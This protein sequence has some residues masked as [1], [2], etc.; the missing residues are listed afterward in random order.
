MTATSPTSARP[1]ASSPASWRSRPAP[2]SWPAW[3]RSASALIAGVVCCYAVKLKT[4]AGY[5]DALDVVG[6]HFV[7]G[8]VG[9]LLIGFFAEPG[10][11]RRR[12]SRRASS[13]AAALSL[14]GEQA[15][16]NGVAIVW[17][18]VVTFVIMLALKDTIGVRVSEEAEDAGLDLAEH[19]ETAYHSGAASPA[20]IGPEAEGDSTMKLITAVIKPFKLDDVKAALKGA[21]VV[22]HH[23]HRG[24]GASAARAAT[25]RSTGAP[26]TRSTSCPR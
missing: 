13:T 24:P 10:V 23:R 11:L 7:G 25:P 9:S 21:G 18:F 4:K 22:G 26:S 15:L 2:A 16:A 3:R 5:D 17:S 20:S 8:L 6:V 19:G 1:R 14:L 12:R